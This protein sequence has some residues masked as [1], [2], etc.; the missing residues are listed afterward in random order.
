MNTSKPAS[1]VVYGLESTQSHEMIDMFMTGSAKSIYVGRN[2][3]TPTL[4]GMLVDLSHLSNYMQCL[5][6]ML[7]VAFSTGFSSEV[8]NE[9]LNT[10]A[11]YTVI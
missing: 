9:A 2:A 3:R 5:D 11:N 1:Y 4:D 7:N 6:Q 8:L 10:R